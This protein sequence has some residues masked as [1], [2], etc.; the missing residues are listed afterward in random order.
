MWYLIAFKC[1]RRLHPSIVLMHILLNSWLIYEISNQI[2]V[3]NSLFWQLFK[4]DN[5]SKSFEALVLTNNYLSSDYYWRRTAPKRRHSGLGSLIDCVRLWQKSKVWKKDIETNGFSRSE[6][7]KMTDWSDVSQKI[8]N[9]IDTS[10]VEEVTKD[11]YF[12]LQF[13]SIQFNFKNW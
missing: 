1:F 6:N 7:V 13:N 5:R 8:F 12:K 2:S 4:C 11:T 10:F 3:T 9:A